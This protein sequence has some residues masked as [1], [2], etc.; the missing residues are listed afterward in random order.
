M[1]CS[2][3]RLL[4]LGVAFHVLCIFSVFDIYFQSSVESS[5]RSANF[6]SSP[7]AKRVVIFTLDGCRVDK[8]FKVVAGHADHYDLNP[9][10]TEAA[11]FNSD[12]RVPFLGQVMRTKGSWG[13]S[14]NHAP[15]ES[16]PCHVALTAGMYEDPHAV[17][18]RWK[19]HP[20][21]FD[22]VFNQSN[23]AFIFGNK[24]VAPIL[25]A[26]APQ[27]VEEH[28]TGREE[29]EMAREDTT[30]LDVWAYRKMKELFARGKK[31]RDPELYEKL[32]DDKLVIYCHFLGTD[33]TGPK[34]GADSREYLEN[35]AVV[36]DLIEKTQK[37]IEEYYGNDGQTAYIVNAD[38]GM[39]LG[40][41]HGDDAPE[42]T[43]TAIIAWG[44]GVQGP[45]TAEKTI[46]KMFDIDLPTR[47]R[48]EIQS[49]LGRQEHEEQVAAREWGS[50]LNLKRKDV[51]QTD[52]AALITALAGLPYPRNSVGVLPFTYLV[53]DK[54][55]AI[56]IR[57]NARQL[58]EHA[59]RKEKVKRAH[60]GLLFVPY[61]PLH[62]R[63]EEL[64][65]QIDEAINSISEGKSHLIHDDAYRVVELLSQEMV[66]IC[67]KAIVYY[68]TYDWMFMRGSIVLSCFGW[69]LVMAVAYRKPQKF[70]SRWLLTHTMD[71]KL[72]AV[73]AAVMWW[74]FLA[75]SPSTHY[76]YGLCPLILWKFVWRHRGQLYAALPPRGGSR[77]KWSVQVALTFLCLEL[78]VFGYH[79]R[80]FFCLLFILLALH[81]R[82]INNNLLQAKGSV[83][84][85]DRLHWRKWLTTDFYWSTSCVLIAVFPCLPSGHDENTTLVHLGALLVLFS[86]IAV[87]RNTS[88]AHD[89]RSQWKTVL[90]PGG[91]PVLL[92]MLA[93]EWTL[94]YLESKTT[95]PWLLVASNWLIVVVPITWLLVQAMCSSKKEIRSLKLEDNGD[96]ERQQVGGEVARLAV[97][98]LTQAI[99]AVTPGLILL[100]TSYEVLFFAAL[101]SGVVSWVMTE[102]KQTANG[103]V[104][105]SREV[106]RAL[107][108]LLFVQVSFFGTNSVA[109]LTSFKIPSTQR[110]LTESSILTAQALVVLKLAIPF[111][112]VG[113][114]FRLI[115]LLPSGAV[116]TQEKE[117]RG[118]SL[119]VPRYFLLTASLAEVL[120]TQFLFLVNNEGSWRQ[121]GNSIAEFCIIN[122]QIVLLPTLVILASALIYDLETTPRGYELVDE[123]EGEGDKDN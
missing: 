30:L 6:T 79:H 123:N 60:R 85:N 63:V 10:S 25:A 28:Y 95:P 96:L 34:F 39:D 22:S 35:I 37:M 121:M 106:Q 72:L 26:H 27:A 83:Q 8:L 75:D 9:S 73:V 48:A 46:K 87:V 65:A 3:A 47:S 76:L 40:G 91:L 80:E 82:V 93:L 41:D 53:K 111:V 98:R 104:S 101:S 31:A 12:S 51:M 90:L 1:S 117:L 44:A 94:T 100:S 56:A 89:G 57:A 32:H 62:D 120:V 59:L 19:Q 77:W 64:E 23:N 115:L 21:P 2:I 107:L 5:I 13:V 74:R 108:L 24:D 97:V 119:W 49:R 14:H 116:S 71:T 110:F 103:G 7:P 29:V 66:D 92:A 38:H 122:A 86:T 67:R 43:R 4:L 99:L 50:V 68:Q 15:T 58:Y 102:A 52:V 45:E 81:P 78:V 109:S 105:A 16:R 42:K 55:R 69:A 33:L 36:D 70:H 118:K 54:Y 17:Y 113:C 88:G 84:L 20:V 112:I 114:A 18:K 11:Q 61:S